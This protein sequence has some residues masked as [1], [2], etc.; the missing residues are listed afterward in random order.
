M[1]LKMKNIVP[2]TIKPFP[3]FL[4]TSSYLY[5]RNCIVCYYYTFCSLWKYYLNLEKIKAS[6]HKVSNFWGMDSV[7]SI[8]K[9]RHLNF[10]YISLY[11]LEWSWTGAPTAD[12]WFCIWG[13]PVL[14]PKCSATPKNGRGW[15]FDPRFH[16]FQAHTRLRVHPVLIFV[17]THSELKENFW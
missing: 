13:P 16:P 8:R 10:N 5:Q 15:G 14:Y 17:I 7:D 2:N 12:T 6:K 4:I 11:G 3:N 1:N 9:G